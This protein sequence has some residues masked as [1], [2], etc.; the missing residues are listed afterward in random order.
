MLQNCVG[1][2]APEAFVCMMTKKRRRANL[3]DCREVADRPSNFP[4]V[5]AQINSSNDQQN[6]APPR[7]RHAVNA[8]I[9]VAL[10]AAN[11]VVYMLLKAPD[12]AA[13]SLALCGNVAYKLNGVTRWAMLRKT[14]KQIKALHTIILRRRM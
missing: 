9:I 11:G 1:E 7:R 2:N 4:A 3:K 12:I 13:K 5:P 14:F 8:G 10:S 6:C